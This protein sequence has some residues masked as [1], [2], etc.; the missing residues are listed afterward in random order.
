MYAIIDIE[1]TGGN[2]KTGK[3]TEVAI[4]VH[5]GE[6]VVNEFVS[7]INPERR[8]PYYISELTGIY[9]HMVQSAP[10][11]YEVAKQI[12]EITEDCIFVAHNANFDYHFIRNEFKNLGYDY[13]RKTLC[14]V[15]LSRKYLPGHKSYS[16]GKLCKDLDIQLTRHHRAAADAEAT[17]K[18]FELLLSVDGNQFKKLSKKERLAIESL[19]GHP[20]KSKVLEL[21]QQAGVY[22]F[23]DAEG[24]LIY[25]GKSNNIRSR[26]MTH[27]GNFT[28]KKAVAM[29][30]AIADIKVEVTGSELVALIK[31][32]N[33]IK[34][35]KPIFNHA[36]RRSI[37]SYGLF[38]NYEL[39]GYCHLQLKQVHKHDEPVTT[40]TT[41]EEG[42]SYV[43]RLMEEFKL[44][45]RLVGLYHGQ[46]ACF[47][48]S[49]H[50]CNGACIGEEEPDV[51]NARV[52]EAIATIRYAM[53]SFIIVDVGRTKGEHSV[54]WIDKYRYRGFGYITTDELEAA[55][56]NPMLLTN[57]I[58]P[59]A[60]N[61]NIQQI[62]RG[63]LER[64]EVEQLIP[65]HHE[66]TTTAAR[67]E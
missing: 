30:E 60:D 47:K 6:Q 40:F 62:I 37:Y 3:I 63:Y 29:R 35:H 15:K 1:T 17:V 54:I 31:E 32:S 21:P 44:C 36:Q 38:M 20:L 11:F 50:E 39:D 42:R 64:N 53:P 52:M 51:Y 45:Q 34:E 26:V 43:E 57:C 67:T 41:R 46:G 55:E 66:R 56:D 33:D 59:Y 16:L 12:V 18:L 7:L 13:R 49:V 61:R 9:D 28:T 24:S 23:F 5:D 27:I 2:S 58:T 25:I 10:K 65:L 14:T 4:Y 19:S 48:H 22:N 8:I